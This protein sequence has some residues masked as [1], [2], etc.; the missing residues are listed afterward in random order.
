MKLSAA[1]SLVAWL[2][3]QHPGLIYQLAAKVPSA[4]LGALGQC[5][6]CD[7]DLLT[8]GSCGVLSSSGS[9]YGVTD[10]TCALD[11]VSLD[12]SNL[13]MPSL[14][15]SGLDTLGV[16]SGTCIPTLT[17]ADLTPVGT[18]AVTGG[19]NASIS[20]GTSVS[21]TDAATSSSLSNVASYVASGVAGLAALAKVAASYFNAQAASSAAAAAAAKTQA[22]IVAA[23]TS[24]AVTGQNELP[25]PVVA[26]GISGA[27]RHVDFNRRGGGVSRLCRCA[28]IG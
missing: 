9:Y 1:Q 22:A 7:L 27:I 3:D 25:H 26:R 23:Q 28:E 14:G 6:S 16:D 21:S 2:W 15:C 18:C 5:F 12:A 4:G 13:D 17:E 20:C 10:P 11:P 24:R 8:G 19:C